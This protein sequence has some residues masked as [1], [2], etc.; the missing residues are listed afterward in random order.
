MCVVLQTQF[1]LKNSIDFKAI[2]KPTTELN[3]D[4]PFILTVG[5]MDDSIKQIDHVIDAYAFK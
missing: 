5:R 1:I 4:V 3:F 2:E